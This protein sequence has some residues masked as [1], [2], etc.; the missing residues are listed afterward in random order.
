MKRFELYL[1]HSSKRVYRK[2]IIPWNKGLSWDDQKITEEKRKIKLSNLKKNG[3][4]GFYMGKRKRRVAQFS[5]DWKFASAR[6]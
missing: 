3:D 1:E 5:K 2:G 6:P 4:N